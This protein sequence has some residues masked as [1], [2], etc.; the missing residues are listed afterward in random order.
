[1]RLLDNNLKSFQVVGKL[2]QWAYW[3]VGG[4]LFYAAWTGVGI[5]ARWSALNQLRDSKDS[6][7]SDGI[8]EQ[9]TDFTC[10]PSS[11]VMLLRD[12]GINTTTYEVAIVADTDIRGTD[13][14]GIV[15]AAGHFGF[16]TRKSKL[17]FDQFM[18]SNLPGILI[19]RRHGTKHAAYI[20]PS[21]DP[22]LMMAK[23]PVDG[24]LYF[25][26]D[27][28]NEWFG[29]DMWEVYLFERGAK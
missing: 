1:M 9:A 20:L 3:V 22:G 27:D 29:S 12:E 8:L 5:W 6:W 4:I 28:A 17:T 19:F 10:V 13:G 23:D 14:S 21:V 16:H 24:I 18:S 26:K 11:I 25:S 15:K 2:P 7:T